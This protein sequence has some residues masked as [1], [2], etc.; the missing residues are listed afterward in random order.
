MR[1]PLVSIILT[2]YKKRKYIK[3]TIKSIKDQSYKNFQLICVYDDTDKTDL[4][5]LKKLIATHYQYNLK[6]ML[7]TLYLI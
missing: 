2:Y 3:K 1:E 4:S 5:Y 6:I 7:L